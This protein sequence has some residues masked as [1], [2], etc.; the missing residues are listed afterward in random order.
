ME[1][2]EI[3]DNQ[4]IGNQ[5]EINTNAILEENEKLKQQIEADKHIKERLAK[6]AEKPKTSWEID[7]DALYNEFKQ[8][9]DLDTFISQNPHLSHLG[10]DFKKLTSSGW[11]SKEEAKLV[12]EQRDPT[13]AQRQK[14]ESMNLA[15]WDFASKQEY[16]IQELEDMPQDKYNQVKSL[17]KQG[18]VRIVR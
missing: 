9:Q 14:T 7:K 1:N 17:E 11:L 10:E 16:T 6:K 8:R 12:L 15:S 5:E 3:I 18:K 13:I 4:E 2:I